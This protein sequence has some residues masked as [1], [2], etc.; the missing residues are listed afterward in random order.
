MK[1]LFFQISI[2]SMLQPHVYKNH[3]KHFETEMKR[4]LSHEVKKDSRIKDN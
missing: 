4:N 1:F 2:I 3:L